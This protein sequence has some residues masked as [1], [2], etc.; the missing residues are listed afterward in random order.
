VYYVLIFEGA[1]GIDWYSYLPK[2][3]DVGKPSEANI[4]KIEKIRKYLKR[5]PAKAIIT[6]SNSCGLV[7]I[8]IQ[9]DHSVAHISFNHHISICT[10]MPCLLLPKDRHRYFYTQE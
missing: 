4:Y 7:Q 9:C 6:I 1:L 8:K 10:R 3:K 2:S 5:Y